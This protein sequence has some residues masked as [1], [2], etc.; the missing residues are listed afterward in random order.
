MFRENLINPTCNSVT[1]KA[2]RKKNKKGAGGGKLLQR[3]RVK[4]DQSL[5][6]S[7]HRPNQTQPSDDLLREQVIIQQHTNKKPES[8]VVFALC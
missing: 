8:L 7:D 5:A 4:S 3:T 6:Y 2:L 1:Q